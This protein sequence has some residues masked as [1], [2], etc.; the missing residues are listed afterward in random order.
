MELSV[1][2]PTI[3]SRRHFDNVQ[4]EGAYLKWWARQI[5]R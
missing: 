2:E 1:G 4:L 5:P 3:A